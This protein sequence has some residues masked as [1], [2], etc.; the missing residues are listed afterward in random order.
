MKK[1]IFKLLF[2]SLS[3][4]LLLSSSSAGAAKK[5]GLP[6]LVKDGFDRY[7]NGSVV[8]QGTWSSYVNGGNFLVQNSTT[9][10]SKEALHN[11]TLGDSVITKAG[12]TLS[13]G[14][15]AVYVRTENRSNWG[16][17]PDGNAQ[18]RVSKGPWASGAPGLAFAAVSFKSDGNVAYYDPVG[19]VYKN[20]TTYNDNEWT[21]LEIEWRSSDKTARYRANSGTWTE[22]STFANSV[23][24]TGF[25]N[26]G[27]AFDLPSG[28][29]GVYFDTLN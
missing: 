22:W 9:L 18:V 19:D 17:Y 28:S 20:F 12:T 14:R 10:K 3:V 13:D 2:L 29:G 25:D 16:L 27:L 24:F 1:S 6:S 23:S 5:V 21:L 26:V 15:Q 7:I 8:G 4:S 11:S